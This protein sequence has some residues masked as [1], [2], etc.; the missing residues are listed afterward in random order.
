MLI[1]PCSYWQF[2]PRGL[3]RASHKLL[4][5]A[6]GWLK[7]DQL[8]ISKNQKLQRE[9]QFGQVKNAFEATHSDSRAKNVTL[10]LL[11]TSWESLKMHCNLPS[12][13]I[14]RSPKKQARCRG[15]SKGQCKNTYKTCDILHIC[16]TCQENYVFRIQW[17]STKMSKSLFG[18]PRAPVE[19]PETP[20][21]ATTTTNT[22]TIY[23]YHYHRMTS[24]WQQYMKNQWELT[25][26][27]RLM[28]N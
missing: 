16:S 28:S 9:A 24:K 18:S 3:Q 11:T 21:R 12:K 2:R 17:F 6:D 5:L 23:Q 25:H 13:W 15:V 14:M 19:R 4:T 26:F 8:C 1:K 27:A 20:P 22:T 10:F 7:S